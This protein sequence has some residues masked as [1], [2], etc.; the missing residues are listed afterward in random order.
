VCYIHSIVVV[1]VICFVSP[2]ENLLHPYLA[3]NCQPQ[4]HIDRVQNTARYKFEFICSGYPIDRLPKHL[5]QM[6]EVAKNAHTLCNMKDASR[7]SHQENGTVLTK[8]RG[9]TLLL[10]RVF[11]ERHSGLP[12]PPS[13][14]TLLSA[15][16]KQ[17][18]VSRARHNNRD[19]ILLFLSR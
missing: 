19:A 2:R 14:S 10:Y 4:V 13:S 12:P 15:E 17:V 1:K 18:R 6:N 16:K 5:V 7:C 9:R 3:G 8:C 11:G